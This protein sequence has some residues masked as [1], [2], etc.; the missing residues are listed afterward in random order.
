[1]ICF[2][3]V[4]ELYILI[5]ILLYWSYYRYLLKVY[6]K[7]FKFNWIGIKKSCGLFLFSFELFKYYINWVYC[8][9]G[10]ELFSC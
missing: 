10:F 2:L 3:L 7:K 5:C 1:M 9:F 4:D 6:F 8:I